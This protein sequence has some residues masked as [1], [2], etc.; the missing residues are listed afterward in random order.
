MRRLKMQQLTKTF[1]IVTITISLIMVML[2]LDVNVSIDE[3]Q[4][5][6]KLNRPSMGDLLSEEPQRYVINTTNCQI[7]DFDP[8]D[9]D[10][11]EQFDAEEIE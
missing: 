5:L 1:G 9:R 2:L 4:P 6:I 8:F 7:P 11:M 10:L 3:H